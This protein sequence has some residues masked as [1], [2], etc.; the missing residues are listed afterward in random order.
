MRIDLTGHQIELSAPLRD[1]VEK[2]IDRLARHYDQHLE[3]R[4]VLG[5]EGVDQKAE[6]TLMVAGRQ[7]HAE[8]AGQDM[9][10]AI[11]VLIDK[12]DRVL[13]KHKEKITDHH[14]GE[15]PARSADFG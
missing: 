7:L 8:A 1:Y 13:M 10:A 6:A 15:S 9:Y 14:R 11:D 2:K 12:L 4:V 5:L 3:A